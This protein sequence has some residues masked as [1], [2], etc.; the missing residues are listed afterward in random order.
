M[1]GWLIEISG[2]GNPHITSLQWGAASSLGRAPKFAPTHLDVP[3]TRPTCSVASGLALGSY[4][5]SEVR[6][7]RGMGTDLA[8]LLD[9]CSCVVVFGM[10]AVR[11][12]GRRRGGGGGGSEPRKFHGND[13]VFFASGF[14]G[15]RSFS[16]KCLENVCICSVFCVSTV[17][18][19]AIYSFSGL[20]DMGGFL[21]DIVFR[22]AALKKVFLHSLCRRL[23][24][25]KLQYLYLVGQRV[26]TATASFQ[27]MH[28]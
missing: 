28:N 15:A 2:L 14:V 12:R 1:Q 5:L 7:R 13:S 24:C 9:V 25:Q 27:P 21:D 6:L 23:P 18:S 3:C 17:Q 19:A 22:A 20:R 26:P 4:A 11:R 10:W 8:F 16:D